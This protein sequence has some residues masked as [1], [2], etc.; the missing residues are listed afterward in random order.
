MFNLT[1]RKALITGA[2]GGIGAAIART[3]HAQGAVVAIS[4]TRVEAL[5]ALQTE[6]G[7][8]RVFIAPCNL[9]DRTAVENLVPQACEMLGGLD[10]LVNNAGLTRDGLILRMKDEDW[11]TVLAVNLTATFVLS[12]AAVKVMMKQRYGRLI[13]IASVVGFSGNP[14]QTN[15]VASKAGLVGFT[16]ALAKEIA[17]RGVTANCVAPG[18][19]A[20]PMTDVLNEAQKQQILNNVPAGSLGTPEDIAAAATFLASTEAQYVTGTT[21]HVNGG[22]YM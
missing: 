12:R 2:S 9:S 11:D 8:E 5:Q 10:I 15:Y 21:I 7:N 17:S 3:L 19:I 20:T 16:K 14:G 6:L 22:M 18:F 13:N 1:G 4:G